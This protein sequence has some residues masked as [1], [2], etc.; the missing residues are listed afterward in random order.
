MKLRYV[1]LLLACVP[2]TRAIGPTLPLQFEDER[3][4]GRNWYTAVRVDLAQL[5][6]PTIT[7]E[8]YRSG[9][10]VADEKLPVKL[11]ARQKDEGPQRVELS[12]RPKSMSRLKDGAYAQRVVVE[13]SWRNKENKAPLHIERWFYF[14]VRDKSIVPL[15]PEEYERLTDSQRKD[16]ATQ[17]AVERV[18][19]GG[20]LTEATPLSR[21]TRMPAIRADSVDTINEEQL[22]AAAKA[23]ASQDEKPDRS[24]ESEP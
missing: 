22:P 3:Y 10:R 4:A 11:P 13:S 7:R 8:I 2:V 17:N 20:G 23:A 9:E 18:Y 5:A 14:Q 19:L 16:T 12:L 21:T 6:P 15:S 24:E 1:L